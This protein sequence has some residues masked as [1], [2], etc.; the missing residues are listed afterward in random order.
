[1]L[2]IK[3]EANVH[4]GRDTLYP[5]PR[6]LLALLRAIRTHGSLLSAIRETGVSYRHAWG[7]LQRWEAISGHKLAVLAR[8][9]GTGLTSFGERLAEMDDWLA[10]RVGGRLDHL[11]ADLERHLD[12]ADGPTIRTLRIHASHDIAVLK[13]KERASRHLAL[14][15]R[16][17]GSLDSLDALGRGDCDIAGFHLP[18]PPALLGALLNEF[19]ARLDAREH[20][21]VWLLSRRQGLMVAHGNPKRIRKVADLTRRG[22]HFVNRERGS[23]TRLLFDALLSRQQI[24]PMEIDGYDTEEFT[25]MATAATVRTGMADAT[26]GIEA[27]ARAHGLNFLPIATERYYFACRRNRPTEIGL[28]TLLATAAS[29]VFKR[30]IAKIGGYDT[31]MKP[32]RVHLRD[33]FG[34][35]TEE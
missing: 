32:A 25:H 8:G 6:E 28:N 13:L 35:Q 10:S 21:I 30:A 14:D 2:K 29:A 19:R 33:L 9:R 34:R 31:T 15:I 27:A 18:D 3:L 22:L 24:S 20:Y 5:V 12:V 4:I 7:L 26:F 17:E 1:M 23:G 11:A 16:F